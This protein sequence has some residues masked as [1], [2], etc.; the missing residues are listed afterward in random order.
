MQ[1]KDKGELRSYECILILA[2]VKYFLYFMIF[3]GY[4]LGILSFHYLILARE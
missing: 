1:D 4:L 3:R 2:S